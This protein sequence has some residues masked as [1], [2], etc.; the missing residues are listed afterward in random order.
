MLDHTGFAVSDLKKSKAFYR[1]ALQPLGIDLLAELTAEETGGGAHAGFG[2]A[3]KPFFWIG[4]HGPA[5]TGVHI[6]FAAQTRA[7]VDSFHSA[8][9]EAGGRD[10]GAPGLRPH[11]HENYYGAFVLDPDGNN[12]EA[13]CHKP[14]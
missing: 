6:A 1:S 2:A 3:N 14:A 8:A 4:D 13:V 12:I 11:Y 7:Q 9:L 10:N 5:C